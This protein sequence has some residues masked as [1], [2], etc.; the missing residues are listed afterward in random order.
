MYCQN[1]ISYHVQEGDT[2]YKL[3]KQFHTTVTELILLNS[4][5][6]PY[7]LKEGMKLTICPGEGY[8]EEKKD[9]G[10]IIIPIPGGRPGNLPP[11][12]NDRPSENRPSQSNKP[13]GMLPP[14]NKKTDLTEQM[15]MAWMDQ[16]TYMKFYLTGI[17]ENLAAK[18]DWK[19]AVQKNIETILSIYASY[20]PASVVQRLRKL[21]M[22]HLWLTEKVAAELQ[23]DITYSGEI[24]ENWYTNAEEAA[25]VL[26]RQT[27]AYQEE[28]L[29]K[30]FYD[31]LD[32]ERQQME[33]YL[34]GEYAKNIAIYRNAMQR[35]LELADVL[36]SGLRAR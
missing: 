29:R 12:G 33:T 26:S 36:A 6:N 10:P 11:S 18:N 23:K 19:D 3:S 25:A 22:E 27:P 20:Y 30:M 4:G 24:M 7:N 15:R 5:I 2:L 13:S 34:D 1:R 31:Q 28:E 21:F 8:E 9:I 14:D 35:V 17:F 32:L 16:I